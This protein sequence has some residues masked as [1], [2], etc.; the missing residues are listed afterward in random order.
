MEDA[1]QEGG[2]ALSNIRTALNPQHL[3]YHPPRSLLPAS[4]EVNKLGSV[5]QVL[6]TLP[7]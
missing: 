1:R 7:L 5:N 2:I 4:A 3:N 6:V